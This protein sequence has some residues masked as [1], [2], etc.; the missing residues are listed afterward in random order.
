MRLILSGDMIQADEA[1]AIG[2][3][4]MV[5]PADELRAKTLEIAQRIACM[6]PLTLK[7]A[8]ESM[9]AS[10]KLP[11]EDGLTYERD[12]FCLCFSTEDKKEGVDAFLAKRTPEW[13][14]R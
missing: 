3:V 11:I 8:K 14:G 1:K 4:D 5:V 13:K 6:S 9:R 10:E 12:L 7:I 2:L